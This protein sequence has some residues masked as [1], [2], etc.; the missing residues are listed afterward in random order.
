MIPTRRPARVASAA[1]RMIR[2][3]DQ[4]R[5]ALVQRE[6]RPRR[7]V[8]GQQ[9]RRRGAPHPVRRASRAF[10]HPARL[11]AASRSSPRQAAR[12]LA[13]CRQGRVRCSRGRPSWALHR[14]PGR[15][16]RRDPG[17]RGL[18]ASGLDVRTGWRSAR[19]P[20]MAAASITAR[21]TG[22]AGIRTAT[23]PSPAVTSSGTSADRGSTIVS[24]PGQKRAA[25]RSTTSGR[26]ETSRDTSSTEAT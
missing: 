12:W 19:Q 26:L 20:G 1:S 21:A 4:V 9:P 24:G 15:C 16:A 7:V 25:S 6:R 3:H 5:T 14:R 8:S 2:P 23:V 22:C 17:E 13:C 10:V 18:P 11:R